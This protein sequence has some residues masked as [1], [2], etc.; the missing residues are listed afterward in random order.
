MVTWNVTF[1]KTIKYKKDEYVNIK[2]YEFIEKII[3]TIRLEQTE[4]QTSAIL[5]LMSLLEEPYKAQQ[6]K[7]PAKPTIRQNIIRKNTY[8]NIIMMPKRN[9][10]YTQ[11]FLEIMQNTQ[12]IAE[13][14]LCYNTR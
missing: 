4:I 11:S 12:N 2:I 13:R 3:K 14:T 9:L 6:E 10:K 5:A 7:Q 1:N 8:L